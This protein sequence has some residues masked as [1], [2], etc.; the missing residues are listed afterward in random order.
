MVASPGSKTYGRLTIMLA[1]WVRIE[2]LLNVGPGAFT[3]APKVSSAVVR[4]T[5]LDTPRF[6]IGTAAR[7]ERVVRAAFSHRRKTLRNALKGTVDAAV[8]ERLGIDPGAR[9]E[10]L[11][12]AQYG[13]LSRASG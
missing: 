2:R 5:P 11:A 10:Q 7:F 3:P 4:L 1:P 6:D 9:P 8:L 13:A 12:P